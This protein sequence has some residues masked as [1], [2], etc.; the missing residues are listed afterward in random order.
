MFHAEVDKSD[1]SFSS[2][3]LELTTSDAYKGNRKLLVKRLASAPES[4]QKKEGEAAETKAKALLPTLTK[5][6]LAA[7][8]KLM[9]KHD[10]KLAG[11]PITD[12]MLV[13]E[14]ATR[15]QI[16][17]LPLEEKTIAA[18]MMQ[19]NAVQLSKALSPLLGENAANLIFGLGVLGMGF[20]T[21]II[22]ML[23]NGY[24]FCEAVGRPK[25][26]PVFAVGCLIAGV[27]GACWPLFWDGDA[28]LYLSIV[29]STFGVILLPIA[30]ITFMLMMNSRALLGDNR[31]QGANMIIWNVLMAVSVAGALIAA[32]SSLYDK[33]MKPGMQGIT[34]MAMAAV[35]VLVVIVCFF[36]KPAAKAPARDIDNEDTLANE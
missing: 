4:D 20:S 6:D 26:R 29:A 10:K 18:S 22:L 15:I 33:A 23:I 36:V 9:V 17:N 1:P 27:A 21:I 8:K 34:V 35:Y 28:R 11:V 25:S 12:E 3:A 5:E 2:G 30:Y 16:V 32:G 19:R 14:L 7:M 24:A 31:P 13:A